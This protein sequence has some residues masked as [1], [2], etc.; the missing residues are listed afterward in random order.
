MGTLLTVPSYNP[1]FTH[2]IG[3]FPFFCTHRLGIKCSA[4]LIFMSRICSSTI[5]LFLAVDE[6]VKSTMAMVRMMV[7]MFEYVN[8]LG[9]KIL[10]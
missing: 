10:G 6:T 4:H 7:F 3:Q 2:L 5:Q 8:G 9:K 1:L